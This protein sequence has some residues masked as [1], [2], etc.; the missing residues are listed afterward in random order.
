MSVEPNTVKRK[1][2]C[3]TSRLA[4]AFAHWS[5][6]LSREWRCSGIAPTGEAPTTSEWPT[7]WLPTEIHLILEV[8]RYFKTTSYQ[9]R[10]IYY[11]LWDI[12]RFSWTYFL[13][14]ATSYQRNFVIFLLR[15]LYKKYFFPIANDWW[16]VFFSIHW[17]FVFFLCG[18][19]SWIIYGIFIAVSIPHGMVLYCS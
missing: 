5:R 10:T 13:Y 19:T 14:L 3:F 8:L 18:A 6:V 1:I 11:R 16:H 17:S 9:T 7:I 15:C 2:K 12:K 4:I